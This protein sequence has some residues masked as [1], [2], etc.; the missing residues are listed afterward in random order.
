MILCH[1]SDL[2][3]TV[4]CLAKAD[5]I[6]R[7]GYEADDCKVE[8]KRELDFMNVNPRL[9]RRMKQRRSSASAP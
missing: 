3:R 6:K 7:V 5:E 8:K 1:I 2:V 4:I 9:D